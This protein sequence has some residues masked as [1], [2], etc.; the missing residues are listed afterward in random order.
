[1]RFAFAGMWGLRP[2]GP[3][4]RAPWYWPAAPF[5]FSKRTSDCKKTALGTW[6]HDTAASKA[7]F[8]KT[9]YLGREK[10]IFVLTFS[11]DNFTHQTN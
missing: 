5:R 11:R 7:Q 9:N 8:C 6:K 4:R 10:I 3:T 2:D 1:M